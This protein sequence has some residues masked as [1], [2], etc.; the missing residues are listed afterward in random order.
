MKLKSILIIGIVILFL[1]CGPTKDQRI[2]EITA[3]EKVL[4]TSSAAISLEKADSMLTKYA[5]FVEEFPTD[6]LSAKYLY[7]SGVISANIGECNEAVAFFDEVIQKFPDLGIAANSLLQKGYTYE[8]CLKDTVAAR[9][10][11]TVFIQ[12]YPRHP[13]V[14]EVEVLLQMLTMGDNLEL[15]RSFEQKNNNSIQGE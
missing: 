6:T 8:T 9:E 5:E 3:M 4:Q 11:Y 7:Q 12:D 15:V 1:G 14:K 2:A 13:Y 10:A